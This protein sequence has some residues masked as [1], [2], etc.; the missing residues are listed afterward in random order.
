VSL[1]G[2]TSE[3]FRAEISDLH[4]GDHH[5]EEACIY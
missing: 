2:P 1:F 3:L 4:L 5:M